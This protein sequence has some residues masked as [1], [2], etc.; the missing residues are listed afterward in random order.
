[1]SLCQARNKLAA[2]QGRTELATTT[3][4]ALA[5]IPGVHLAECEPAASAA[6]QDM[7]QLETATCHTRS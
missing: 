2:P 1:M 7:A 6:A 4:A 5:E 3:Q